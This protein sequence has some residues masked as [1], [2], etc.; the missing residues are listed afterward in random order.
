MVILHSGLQLPNCEVIVMSCTS[1]KLSQMLFYSIS[2]C[3]KAFVGVIHVIFSVVQTMS[4]FN[5]G[6]FKGCMS[7]RDGMEWHYYGIV[8]QGSFFIWFNDILLDY[9]SFSTGV[10][11]V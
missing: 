5:F 8:I 4:N 3:F 2:D 6:Y 1:S 11:Y 9:C 7:V 10:G